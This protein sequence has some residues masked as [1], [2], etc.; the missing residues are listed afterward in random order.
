MK[1]PNI[2]NMWETAIKIGKDT[3]KGANP[4]IIIEKV[5]PTISALKEKCGIKWY[6]FLFHNERN[7]YPIDQWQG[8]QFHIRFEKPTNLS[9]DQLISSIPKYCELPRK[10]EINKV[11]SIS[12]IDKS[13]IKN[14]DI[15]EAWRLLGE[16]SKYIID[17]LSSHSIG[18]LEYYNKLKGNIAQ[19]EHFI[20]NMTNV[21][22]PDMRK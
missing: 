16:S 18:N 21:Y 13:I 3:Y 6:C 2:E 10:I 22:P 4:E 7:G 17:M 14:Q 20:I 19:F 11:N 5:I 1:N 15:S 12:G 9:I 8:Y